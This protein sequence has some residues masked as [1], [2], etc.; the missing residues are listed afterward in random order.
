MENEIIAAN[1]L[2]LIVLQTEAMGSWMDSGNAPQ[3][4]ENIE[5]LDGLCNFMADMID[6][7]YV[8]AYLDDKF[9]FGIF[10]DKKFTF[11][12]FNDLNPMHIKRLRIFNEDCELHLWRREIENGQCLFDWRF[13]KDSPAKEAGMD[14]MYAVDAFQSIFGSAIGSTTGNESSNADDFSIL[15]EERVADIHIPIYGI[16]EDRLPIR[17]QT[18]NYVDFLGE[19]GCECLAGY[20]DCRFVGFVDSRGNKLSGGMKDG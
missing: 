12:D 7:G 6:R 14:E 11:F 17:I 15:K 2:R 4:P 5:T 16:T 3:K 8:A 10:K 1:G 9:R 13:R 19:E 18:R 20:V